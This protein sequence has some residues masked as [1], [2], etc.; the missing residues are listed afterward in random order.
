MRD[1]IWFTYKARIQ[2]YKRLDWLDFHSQLL[3]VWY[4]ILSTTLGVLTIRDS[5]LLGP[6]TDVLATILSVALL[7]VSL[8]VTNRDFRVRAML[9]RSN[10]LQLQ[11]LYREIPKESTPT[12]EQAK[13]YDEL[14]AE[15]ENH[16]EI[17]DRIARVFAHG[18]T[19]RAPT[20]FESFY[21]FQWLTLRFLI[22][23]ALYILP[24]I[25]GIYS[26]KAV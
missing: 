4:A 23:A 16:R 15:S 21:A 18:L 7:G 6:N 14:L 11:K 22:T 2:A 9:M 10:Y 17:D 12:T 13:K 5:T 25:A 26:W 24:V 3:L 8:T 19:S 1:N 20:A